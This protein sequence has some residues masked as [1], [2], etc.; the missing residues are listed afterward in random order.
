MPVNTIDYSRIHFDGQGKPYWTQGGG[1]NVYLPPAA[2]LQSR[3]PQAVEWA[4]SMGSAPGSSLTR[5]R[6]HW[7]SGSGQWKQGINWNNIAAI[8]VGGA[9]AAPFVAPVFAGLGGGAGG[10]GATSNAI[11][12]NS[13][14]MFAGNGAFLGGTTAAT[15]AGAGTTAT[16]AGAAG[17]FSPS[18]LRLIELGVGTGSTFMGNRSQGRANDRA[19]RYQAEAD[20]RA[21]ELEVARDAEARRRWEA[22]Q[23]QRAREVA[24]QEEERQYRRRLEEEREARQAPYRQAS[25]QALT[26][27]G[28]LIGL[29]GTQAPPQWLSPSNVGRTP[30]LGGVLGMQ[31]G[32]R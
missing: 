11:G 13:G 4:Q 24:A 12:V 6:G 5:N 8:G 20:Q 7:D 22:E 3:N 15:G 23:E 25:Q 14:G 17:M 1:R 28:D 16:A 26:R 32:G 18:T 10:A 27:L 2:A 30:T 31:G 21:Y 9:M 19:S 29:N